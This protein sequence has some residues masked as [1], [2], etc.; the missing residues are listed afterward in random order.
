MELPDIGDVLKKENEFLR[1]LMVSFL[2]KELKLQPK[3]FGFL[4]ETYMAYPFTNVLIF[5]L[6]LCLRISGSLDYI[7]RPKL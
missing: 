1:V 7:H 3:L 6:Q 4:A 5:K 2:L